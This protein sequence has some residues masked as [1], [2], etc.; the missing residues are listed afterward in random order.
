MASDKTTA[1]FDA[2][3]SKL[4]SLS[5]KDETPEASAAK[6]EVKPVD[7][8]AAASAKPVEEAAAGEELTA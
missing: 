1:S 4:S 8:K 7:D 6:G 2:V 5:A 3:T